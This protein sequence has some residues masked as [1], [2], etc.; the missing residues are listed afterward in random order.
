MSTRFGI[1]RV[2]FFSVGT[3][4]PPDLKNLASLADRQMHL[5]GN[6]MSFLNSIRSK[7]EMDEMTL[8]KHMGSMDHEG[9]DQVLLPHVQAK[10][11]GNRLSSTCVHDP[12]DPGVSLYCV[13]IH[14][15]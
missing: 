3:A 8:I 9:L 10:C 6:L 13:V 12:T 15:T 14:D 7:A 2:M 5:E 11:P 4:P 1:E